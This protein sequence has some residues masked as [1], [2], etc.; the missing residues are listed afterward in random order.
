MVISTEII[1]RYIQNV[2]N[3]LNTPPSSHQTK[4][5]GGIGA[6]FALSPKFAR[7]TA[8]ETIHRLGRNVIYTWLYYMFN[9]EVQIHSNYPGIFDFSLRFSIHSRYK[10]YREKLRVAQGSSSPKKKLEKKT[11][12]WREDVHLGPNV[13]Y[14]FWTKLY[15]EYQ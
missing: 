13:G 6:R 1:G 4:G 15:I 11:G 7:F 5:G 9:K 14:I 8:G 10:T 3:R 12:C 2:F